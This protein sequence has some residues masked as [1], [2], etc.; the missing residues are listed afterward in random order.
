MNVHPIEIRTSISPSSAVELNTTSALANYASEAGQKIEVRRLTNPP[1]DLDCLLFSLGCWLT[2]NTAPSGLRD[3]LKETSTRSVLGYRGLSGC[4]K[5]SLR[6]WRTSTYLHKCGAALLNENWAITAAH[7]VENVCP[8]PFNINTGGD[9]SS[10]PSVPP[11]DL[12]LRLGEHDLSSEDEPYG[13]QE[14]RVQIV[15][16]HPQFD[17]RTFEYDLAL[18][19][20]YEPVVFQPNI[21]PV[22]V[23][24]DDT[25][26]VGRTA[27][28]TGW[29]RLYE[30]QSYTLQFVLTLVLHDP[31]VAPKTTI[32]QNVVYSSPMASLVLT[33]S[34]QLTDKSF[35]NLPDQIIPNTTQTMALEVHPP[36]L[37]PRNV[38]CLSITYL[39]GLSPNGP[40]IRGLTFELVCP[41]GPLPSVLQEVSV[42][43]INNTV[44]ETMYR[45]AG[46]IEH[47]PEIFICAGWRKGGFDSCEGDSGGPMVIQRPDKRWLLAGVISWGIGCAEPNQPGV[48]T[49]I[50]EFRDWINQILQF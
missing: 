6:Q 48:Y 44:C 41:D 33:D 22:C 11:S 27:Y 23:P 1:F 38:L 4:K 13:Y 8:E 14:R 35:E 34:S 45:S 42:P 24:Q 15:A 19:R 21:V 28:V 16:S 18:L 26:F 12:L 46:Y 9:L 7:C 29:G 36:R 20:F 10:S 47:I 40:S 43:V 39:Q 50:S 2:I 17:H 31:I 3:Y 30:D 32:A 49:R 25:N 5:I 37:I